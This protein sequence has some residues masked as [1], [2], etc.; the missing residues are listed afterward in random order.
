M[1]LLEKA[2]HKKTDRNVSAEV[3][4]VLY[5]VRALFADC[6]QLKIAKSDNKNVNQT[7]VRHLHKFESCKES[8]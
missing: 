7:G 1:V 4:R 2:R 6:L 8:T 5:V 3:Q